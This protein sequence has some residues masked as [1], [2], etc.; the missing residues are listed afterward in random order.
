MIREGGEHSGRWRRTLQY[1]TVDT[2]YVGHA[3]VEHSVQYGTMRS[4]VQQGK[5]GQTRQA[6]S[7]RDSDE[8]GCA[9]ALQCSCGRGTG[10]C[11][12]GLVVGCFNEG[13]D[14]IGGMRKRYS[15]CTHEAS[16][17]IIGI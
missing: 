10:M 6:N 9:R 1:L 8:R 14:M 11:D 17:G 15:V 13:Y 5:Q 2:L 3:F 16:I 4:T 12:M 7:K